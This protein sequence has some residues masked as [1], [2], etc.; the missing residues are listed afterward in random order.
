MLISCHLEAEVQ[1]HNVHQ[2]K[3]SIGTSFI[4]SLLTQDQVRAITTIDFGRFNNESNQ[5]KLLNNL[6]TKGAHLG[7]GGDFNYTIV[8]TAKSKIAYIYDI[9]PNSIVF[10]LMIRSAFLNTHSPEAFISYFNNISLKGLQAK[11]FPSLKSNLPRN[12]TDL[13]IIGFIQNKGLSEYFKT[14]QTKKNEFN[15]N[16]TYLGN[17]SVFNHVKSMFENSQIAFSLINHYDNGTFSRIAQFLNGVPI[18]SMYVSNSLEFIW[19][20]NSDANPEG[21]LVN[22]LLGL[23]GGGKVN[24]N[25]LGATLK[26]LEKD[27]DLYINSLNGKAINF[28]DQNQA[29]AYVNNYTPLQMAYYAIG[30]IRFAAMAWKSFWQNTSLLKFSDAAVILSTNR[31]TTIFG[32]IFDKLNAE[33]V[34]DNSGFNWRYS[35]IPKKLWDTELSSSSV[36]N[37]YKDLFNI[38]LNSTLKMLELRNDSPEERSAFVQQLKQLAND[39]P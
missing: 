34:P 2:A 5:F 24:L 28:E 21:Y 1:C 22:N 10:H 12:L 33:V 25:E 17:L 9:D 16:Y 14:I 18:S 27:I 19:M 6:P 15:R 23:V 37:Y 31:D 4:D 11:E 3:N 8:G 38:Y 7:L 20:K 26:G 39:L 13:Q 30:P 32:K 36:S 29:I 35:A